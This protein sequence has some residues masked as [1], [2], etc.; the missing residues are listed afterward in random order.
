MAKQ[1]SSKR[2]FPEVTLDSIRT[3]NRLIPFRVSESVTARSDKL[4][5]AVLMKLF[6]PEW[7]AKHVERSRKGFIREGGS[8]VL[9]LETHRMRRIM[10]AEMLFNMQRIPGFRSCL[11]DLYSGQIEPTYATLEVGRLLCTQALDR[12]RMLFRFVTPSGIQKELARRDYDISIKFSDG[13]AARLE[14]KCK[15][16]E[17]KITIRTIDETLSKA[18]GQLP[19][20]VPGIV[21][22][23]VP[24]N[25]ID[26]LKFAKA[27][28]SL[29][30][31]FLA[32]SPSIVSVKYHTVNIVRQQ[33]AFG[34]ETVGEILAVNERMNP[35]HHFRKLKER[36]WTMFPSTS[37]PA[38][39]P[40]TDYNGMP[41]T[42]QRLIVRTNNL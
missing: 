12:E 42:W 32:R 6:G 9:L 20:T 13:V 38:P 28:L 30:D 1:Q 23:K 14:A 3:L 2:V 19:E 21:F 36:D 24:R 22:V 26:D 34:G 5:K 10:L 41:A 29:A 17:T 25:W 33:D 4:A 8:T 7:I 27:M 37:G 31:R 35:K 39:V 40:Q 15:L 16:E 11:V 18:K